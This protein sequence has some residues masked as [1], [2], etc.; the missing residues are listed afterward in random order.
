MARLLHKA[1]AYQLAQ[2]GPLNIEVRYMCHED[3]FA[4]EIETIVA[5]LKTVLHPDLQV[6]FK[7]VLIFLSTL[8]ASN[9]ELCGNFP[10]ERFPKAN[11]RYAYGKPVLA[12]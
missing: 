10:Y 3:F 12:P 6:T 8:A 4:R 7:R 1:T 2:V 9:N 5:H 11:P